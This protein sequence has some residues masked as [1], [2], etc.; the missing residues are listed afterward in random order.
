[1]TPNIGMTAVPHTLT[2][3]QTSV[4]K[5]PIKDSILLSG[6]A[7]TG[8]TTA[9][10]LR[11]RRLVEQGVAGDSILVLVPQRRLAADY[12]S[13]VR[14][15]DFPAGSQ[16]VILTFNGLAQRMLSLFWPLIASQAGFKTPFVTPRFLNME[17]AQYYLAGIVEPLLDQGYFESLTIDR[18][19]LYSQI[20]DNLNKSAVVGFPPCEIA[21]RLSSAWAGKNPQHN[22]YQQAQECALKFLDFCLANH[23]LDFSLQ[24]SVFTNQIWPSL[25]CRQFIK[26]SYRHLIYDNIEED[27]PVAHDFSAELL[28]DLDSALLIQDTTGGYRS[29]LGADP[30]SAQQLGQLCTGQMHLT[31]SL[32]QSTQVEQLEGALRESILEHRLVKSSTANMEESFSIQSFRFYPQVLDWVTG[33]I[34]G[35][36]QQ[37]AANPGDIAILTPYLSDSLRFSFA[38]RLEKAAIP[39]TTYRPS[40]SLRDEPAVQTVLTLARI[41]H[42]SWGLTPSTQQVRAAF[43]QS[44]SECDFTRADLLSRILFKPKDNQFPLNSFDGIKMEMQSRITYRIG[45]FYEHLRGWLME[46]QGG[47]NIELDHWICR[48]FG[49]R[50]SQPGFG[51]HKDYDASAAVSRLIESCRE[52]RRIFNSDQQDALPDAGAEYTRVLETGILASQSYASNAIQED[53]DVVFLSPAYSFLIRNR[54]VKYQFWVDIGSNGWWSRLDQPLTQPYVLNRNWQSGQKWTDVNEYENNQATLTRIITGLVRRC[55]KHIFMCSVNYNE[56]GIEERG[57]LLLSMQTILRERARQSGGLDV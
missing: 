27:F 20:L 14:S 36:L 40:R 57:Q 49:E 44:I 46:N 56:H 9:G 6:K 1:M 33:E 21:E 48:L 53:A 50:L 19:R 3:E 34:R 7:G 47:G 18:N 17:T 31:A 43:S 13:M 30:V 45:E 23:F 39:F 35:I 51:F 22:I 55:S 4:I 32:V 16:P 15:A 10:V 2:E 5:A 25:L 28:P 26:S 37:G 29:F 42:P 38:H 11:I 24:L 52:F 8:K 41:A 54:P 12:Y